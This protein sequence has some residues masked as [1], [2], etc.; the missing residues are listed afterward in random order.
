MIFFTIMK[1]NKEKSL[2][3]CHKI[4]LLWEINFTVFNVLSKCAFQ[5]KLGG[6][7]IHVPQP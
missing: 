4:Q 5:I 6:K 3:C 1:D 7:S 2:P